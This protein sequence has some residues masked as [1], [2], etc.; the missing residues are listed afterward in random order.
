MPSIIVLSVSALFATCEDGTFDLNG[1]LSVMSPM[2]P[3]SPRSDFAFYCVWVIH[4]SSNFA[5]FIEIIHHEGP[6][7]FTTLIHTPY[8]N[9]RRKYFHFNSTT[10]PA[11][12]TIGNYS[13]I[14]LDLREEVIQ[15]IRSVKEAFYATITPLPFGDSGNHKAAAPHTLRKKRCWKGSSLSRMCNPR[16]WTVRKR[17]PENPRA[18]KGSPGCLK[19]L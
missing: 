9:M 18:L 7:W 14:Q 12:I 17:V 19:N 15:P 5:C 6:D 4:V 1:T 8:I 11:S 2:Y 13:E 3:N 10:A 16:Y